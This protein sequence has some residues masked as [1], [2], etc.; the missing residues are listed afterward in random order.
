MHSYGKMQVVK[1][2]I[3]MRRIVPDRLCLRSILGIGR[4]RI[5]QAVIN[6]L[7]ESKDEDVKKLVEFYEFITADRSYESVVA[8]IITLNKWNN[9]LINNPVSLLTSASQLTIGKEGVVDEKEEAKKDK[10]IDRVLKFIEKQ[11]IILEGLEAMQNK[12]TAEEV[13]NVNNDKRIK[14]SEDRAFKVRK[15]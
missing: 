8:R 7:S 9:D 15:A 3:P 2:A 4:M 10:E 13:A 11:P 14:D 12:W 6:R 1:S 5:E